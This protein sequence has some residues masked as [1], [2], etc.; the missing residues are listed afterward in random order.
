MHVCVCGEKRAEADEGVLAY[1]QG[2]LG[3]W[4]DGANG[5]TLWVG[6]G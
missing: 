6:S 3:V 1:L 4:V 2:Q 5:V